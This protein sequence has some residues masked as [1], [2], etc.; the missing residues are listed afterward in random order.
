MLQSFFSF[1][2]R[3]Y[4]IFQ[5]TFPGLTHERKLRIDKMSKPDGLTSQKEREYWEATHTWG[6]ILPILFFVVLSVT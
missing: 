1:F 2:D 6:K 3:H 5:G 4:E